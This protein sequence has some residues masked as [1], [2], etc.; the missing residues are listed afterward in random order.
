MKKVSP[1]LF[2]FRDK[3][4]NFLL[5]FNNTFDKKSFS[6]AT[7]LKD[8]IKVFYINSKEIFQ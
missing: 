3:I 4:N 7:V 6:S 5:D 2:A 8:I 1:V